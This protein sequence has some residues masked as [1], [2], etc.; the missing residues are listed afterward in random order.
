[1]DAISRI[2]KQNMNSKKKHTPYFGGLQVL[3]SACKLDTLKPNVSVERRLHDVPDGHKAEWVPA[4]DR[5][6]L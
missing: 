4:A 5:V 3:K 2:Y 6:Y 1:M